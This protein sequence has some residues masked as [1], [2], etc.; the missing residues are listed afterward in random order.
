ML[1]GLDVLERQA[2][3]IGFAVE[4]LQHFNLT[5]L[6]TEE[7]L[8]RL[9]HAQRALIVFPVFHPHTP[10]VSAGFSLH[11]AKLRYAAHPLA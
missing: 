2:R 5:L 7:L 3:G 6:L 11:S 10:P 8:E 4:N 9:H 1:A